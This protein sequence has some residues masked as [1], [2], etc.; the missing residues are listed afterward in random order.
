MS[1]SA[2]TLSSPQGWKNFD[3]DHFGV[4]ASALCGVHC[5]VTPFQLLLAPA[6]GSTWSHPASHWIG[7]IIVVPL[8]GGA[9]FRGYSRHG[10]KWIPAAG[11][12]GIAMVIVGACLPF[13]SSSGAGCVDTCCPTLT[14]GADGS[15]SLH[16]PPASVVTVIGGI[17]LVVVHAANLCCC[18]V[19]RPGRNPQLNFSTPVQTLKIK[20]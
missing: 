18:R 16:I 10:R 4:V 7:A 19:C 3:P 11:V 13:L 1:A 15:S 17:A 9:I 20:Q 6:F 12:F 14:T 8:A 5:A 2:S